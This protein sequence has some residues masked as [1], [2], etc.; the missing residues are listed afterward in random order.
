MGRLASRPFARGPTPFAASAARSTDGREGATP[1]PN[2][3]FC[4]A[5]VHAQRGES[6]PGDPGLAR[7]RGLIHLPLPATVA[8]RR[9]NWEFCDLGTAPVPGGFIEMIVLRLHTVPGESAEHGQHE[10]NR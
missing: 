5:R 4:A 9:F 10:A 2:D 6:G 1:H 8:Q 7:C 3:H